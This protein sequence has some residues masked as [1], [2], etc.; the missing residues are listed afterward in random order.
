MFS[1]GRACCYGGSQET[2]LRLL[3]APGCL[4]GDVQ[5]RQGAVAVGAG[6]HGLYGGAYVISRH[7]Q[8]FCCAA[9]QSCVRRYLRNVAQQAGADGVMAGHAAREFWGKEVIMIMDI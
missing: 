8:R 4:L 1:T 6:S 9:W 3:L 7:L 2:G 5:T